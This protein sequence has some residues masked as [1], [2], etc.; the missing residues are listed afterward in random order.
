MS[1]RVAVHSIDKS[2]AGDVFSSLANAFSTIAAVRSVEPSS[3]TGI[4]SVTYRDASNER[5]VR[6]MTRSSLYA[7]IFRAQA[8]H[9]NDSD[10]KHNGEAQHVSPTLRR[11]VEKNVPIGT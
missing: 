10:A 5:T 2:I 11:K 4:S 8:P 9:D 6:S 1:A 3:T 7:G